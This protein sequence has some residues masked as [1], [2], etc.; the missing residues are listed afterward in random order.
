MRFL[1]IFL[2]I[3]LFA[4]LN[5]N[6]NSTY[7]MIKGKY[8]L[9]AV[10]FKGYMIESE[11]EIYGF[12][13]EG[14]IYFIKKE[15]NENRDYNIATAYIINLKNNDLI[16]KTAF[17]F[18][19][20]FSNFLEQNGKNL[21]EIA[22]DFNITKTKNINLTEFPF[23]YNGLTYKTASDNKYYFYKSLKESFLTDFKLVLKKYSGAFLLYKKNI[24]SYE[25]DIEDYVYNIYALGAIKSPKSDDFALILAK[26]YRG[27]EGKP[28]VLDMFVI[29]F[30]K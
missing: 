15:P 23:K 7:L 14:L 30:K 27:F 3:L 29:G 17:N 8:G 25:F 18:K 9:T 4:K 24:F 11:L 22:K 20:K 19:G 1:I 28:H 10:N 16:L 12:N 6:F 2:P 21:Q 13:K 26:I 5:L